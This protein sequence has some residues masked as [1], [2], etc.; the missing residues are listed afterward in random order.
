VKG[1]PYSDGDRLV[2][3]LFAMGED[4]QDAQ[5][6]ALLVRAAA[7]D[8]RA[9]WNALVDR[10]SGLLWSICR[11][12]GLNGAD[13]GDAFQLTWL[14]LLE[15]LDTIE[16]PARLPGWLA[17][18]CRRECMA[19]LRRGKR[20]LPTADDALFD[21][22]AGQAAA[23][24]LA[25]LVSDRDAGLWR[26]FNRLTERCQQI[27]RVLVLEPDDGA[28]SYDWAARML[29][30]PKGSLGPTRGRCLAQL[31]KFLDTEGI[32]GLAGDS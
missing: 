16:D 8:D 27:L 24:D 32:S 14:R 13:A 1:A 29:G 26:A 31:R 2:A 5:P 23:A 18:T 25:T 12:F 9:A 11:S 28:P 21:R 6:L 20:V 30:M 3:R 10:F 4:A 15:H 17:T 19:V 7:A 22:F